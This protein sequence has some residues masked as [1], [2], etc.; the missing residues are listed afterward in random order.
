MPKHYK[1]SRNRTIELSA[2]EITHYAAMAVGN[3][4]KYTLEETINK[5]IHGDSFKIMP[6]LAPNCVDLMIVDPPYN[7]TKTFGQ[8]IFRQRNFEEYKKWAK[9]NEEFLKSERKFRE[10]VKKNGY[11]LKKDINKGWV[12]IGI[13]LATDTTQGYKF[14]EELFD[15]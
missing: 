7:L 15:E 1:A 5:I 10:D 2:Q 9:Q 14:G 6:K 8:N 11:E 13:R 12:Y 3:Q 4:K